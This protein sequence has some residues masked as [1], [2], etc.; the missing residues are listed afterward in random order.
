MRYRIGVALLVVATAVPACTSSDPAVE[1]TSS[2]TA[3][4]NVTAA[5][6][7]DAIE[8]YEAVAPAI[9]FVETDI[10]TGSGI[11][12]ERNILLTAAHVVWPQRNVRVSFPGGGST[13]SAQVLG[14]D[15]LADLAIVDVSG[16]SDLPDPVTT[17]NGEEL[18]IGSPVYM[19]G[20]PA[21]PERNPEPTISEGIL[22]RIR[23]WHSEG[24]TFLQSD[25]AVV[26]G[27]SGG[28][29]VD[30]SGHVIG[31]TNFQLATEYGISGSMLD[32]ADRIEAM[33]T[34]TVRSELGDRL[35]PSSGADE[36][37]T[38]SI[39]HFWEQKAFTF[40]VPLFTEV[41][42]TTN[43][44]ADT[45]IELMTIEGFPL[46]YADENTGGGEVATART[47]LLG[48]HIALVTTWNTGGISELVV[49]STEL[50]LWEDPDDGLVLSKPDKLYGNIDFPGDVDWFWIDLGG[51]Q[52][53]TLEV[54]SVTVDA[55]IYVDSQDN[56][57]EFSLA[58]DDDSGGGPFG[59]NPRLLFTAEDSGE[60]LVI[61]SD[62]HRS[63]PGAY[64][65]TVE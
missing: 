28:A 51:G 43:G 57:S 48:P 17:A 2:T 60:Y 42:V 21:E 3:A 18:P 46:V 20:Y 26:G 39:A 27:Q 58:Y 65:L 45:A 38:V 40:E 8:V 5:P 56:L 14:T 63:G 7:P 33:K 53:V 9:A 25:A 61:V 4:P 11:L 15:L 47:S 62:Q 31:V 54:D 36:T 59:T 35:P 64:V 30:A 13:D 29:L 19:V 24:W 49:G 10:G 22:S 23:E 37:H 50:T 52:A 34:T 16:I 55:T 44:D 1:A 41:E 32:V 6:I 12:I